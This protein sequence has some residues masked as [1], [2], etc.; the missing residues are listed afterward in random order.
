[1][2]ELIPDITPDFKPEKLLKGMLDS[3]KQSKAA[4]VI[5][6]DE[7]NELIYQSCGVKRVDILWTIEKL[8]LQ[9]L[10]VN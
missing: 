8:K 9:V 6:L 2:S 3:A 4:I 10:G 5:L 1:M 7:N